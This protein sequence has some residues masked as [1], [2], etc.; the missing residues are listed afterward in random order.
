MA[1]AAAAETSV[2]G[3]VLQ[4]STVNVERRR[5]H[6]AADRANQ[7]QLSSRS[8][9]AV[10]VGTNVLDDAARSFGWRTWLFINAKEQ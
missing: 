9:H 8:C 4:I 10:K 7:Q 2:I 6:N 1:A 3:G 5:D